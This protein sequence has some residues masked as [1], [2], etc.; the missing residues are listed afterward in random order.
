MHCVI[1]LQT[2]FL[3]LDLALRVIV[4]LVLPLV[5]FVVVVFIDLFLL[6]L[7]K[8]IILSCGWIGDIDVCTQN[9]N[10]ELLKPFG[11]N[12]TFHLTRVATADSGF[13]VCELVPKLSSDATNHDCVV[14]VT[15]K[16]SCHGTAW[17]A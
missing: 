12:V 1:C 8:V 3:V 15:G 13:Y 11:H 17:S 7:L 4:L 9:S 6:L 2:L 14:V 10:V 16:L 5:V